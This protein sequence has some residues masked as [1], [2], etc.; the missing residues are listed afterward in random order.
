MKKII[1]GA[2][3]CLLLFASCSN[4]SRTTTA[5]MIDVN[6]VIVTNTIANLEVGERVSYTYNPESSERVGG[7]DACKKAAVAA[8]L[9]ANGNADVLVAPEFSYKADMKAIEVSGR[10][11]KYKNF[12]SAQ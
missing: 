7:A 2:A 11:A 1:F 10:P 6:N 8:L 3:S 12:R 4:L 9:K 5:T